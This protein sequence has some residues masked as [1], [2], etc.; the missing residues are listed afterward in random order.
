MSEQK[1]MG[2][3]FICFTI[4]SII[5]VYIF[6][7]TSFS[8]SD[9]FNFMAFQKLLSAEIIIYLILMG[10]VIAASVYVL[11]YFSQRLKETEIAV[12]SLLGILF[13]IFAGWGLFSTKSFFI[14]MM[15]FYA[16]GCIWAIHKKVKIKETAWSRA[17]QGW[18]ASRGVFLFLGVGAL[19]GGI[20][21]TYG[22]LPYY[23]GVMKSSALNLTTSVDISSFITEEDVRELVISQELTRA[24][25]EELVRDEYERQEGFSDLSPAEQQRLIDT[26]TEETYQRQLD[27][28]EANIDRAYNFLQE[29]K[30]V[31]PDTV[32]NIIERMPF[33]KTLLDL[34]PFFAGMISLSFVLIFGQVFVSP[35]AAILSIWIK[36]E[37]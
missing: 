37:K 5:W 17:K 23:Q 22:S 31:A 27:G 28:R 14:L 32:S 10:F 3:F 30:T 26:T 12:A 36:K 25:I 16:L 15:I 19:F 11:L 18:V 1:D 33:T 34:L 2:I 29:R 8:Y 35:F 20:V 6:S 9:L 13:V 4:L 24:E 21:V 7:I